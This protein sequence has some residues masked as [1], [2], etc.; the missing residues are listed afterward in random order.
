M[1]TCFRRD[2]KEMTTSSGVLKPACRALRDILMCSPPRCHP[3]RQ[4]LFS[5]HPDRSEAPAERSGR[6]PSSFTPA[7]M[8]QNFSHRIAGAKPVL[9]STPEYQKEKQKFFYDFLCVS[10]TRW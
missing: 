7:R 5:C 10:V 9:G 6:T 8:S 2:S 4:V 1:T 3:N